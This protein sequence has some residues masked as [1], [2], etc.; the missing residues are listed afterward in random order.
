MSISNKTP[1]KLYK[2]LTSNTKSMNQASLKEAYEMAHEGHNGQYRKSGEAYITHPL[3]VAIY[4]AE[5][6]MDEETIIAALLHDVV[7]DTSIKLSTIKSRFGK[8]VA[9][10][11]DGVTKLDKINFSTNEEAKAESIRKMVIAMS[12]DVRVLILKLAD[13]LHN[14]NTIN[15]LPDWKQQDIASETL[16]VYSPLAHRLGLQNVKHQ[17]EDISFSI[18][19]PQQDKEI[20]TQIISTSPN[21]TIKINNTVKVISTLLS[22][23]SISAEVIGRPKHNYSIYKK[24]IN[25]GLSFSEI[26]DLIGIRIICSDVKDCYTVLGLIHAIFNQYRVGLK[27][28]FQC[29][30]S[31]YIKVYIQQY[32][33]QIAEKWRYKLGH[34]KCIL[35]QNME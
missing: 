10:I 22:D 21:R 13:R 32:Y 31:I 12:K 17:L 25:N 33:L 24:I 18:L 28:L 35:E 5:I 20:S 8:D 27:I 26:N 3:H 19:F 14:I 2:E 4:L 34:M 9:L 16:Y 15:S 23:N 1:S 30:N 7:E 6:G 11:V 29:Q